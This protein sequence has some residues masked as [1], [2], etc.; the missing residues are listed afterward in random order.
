MRR[1]YQS[2]SVEQLEHLV[3]AARS[4]G[5]NKT[6]RL[7]ATELEKYRTTQKAKQLLQSLAGV[8]QEAPKPKAPKAEPKQASSSKAAKPS[9]AKAPPSRPSRKPTPEQQQAID[10]FLGRGSLKINAYAGTGKTSTLEMLAHASPARGQY[11]AFNRSIVVEAKERFPSTVDC[12][13]THRLALR[14]IPS[15]Y[16]ESRDKVFGRV[17][18]N[19]LAEVLGLKGNWRVDEGHSLQ[20]RSQAFM[21]LET[22]KRFAQSEDDELLP[23]HVPQHGSLLAASDESLARV[24]DFALHGAKHVWS[25]M[26]D[27]ADK[28][29]LGHDGYLKLWALSKPQIAADYILLD[30]AQDTNPVVLGVLRA[31]PC[32]MIYV[33]DRYQQI[34][35]WR[36]AVNAMDRIQTDAE[37]RLTQ[38]FRFGP[39]IADGAS[40]ILKLLGENVPLTGNPQKQ[41]RIGPCE[42]QT[43]LGRTN[44][45]AM[46]ALIEALNGGKRPHLV[47][48]TD[49]LMK[50]LNGVA[51]LKEGRPVPDV[52][53]FFGFNNWNEVVAFAK[54]PE[55]EQLQ[56]FVNL[57]QSHSERQLKWALHNSVEEEKS[58]LVISTAHKAKGREWENV[59]LMDDFLKSN[60]RAAK[61]K[62]ETEAERAAELRLFYV[63]MTR[64]KQVIEIPEP[65]LK[66]FGIAGVPGRAQSPA[67]TK[68]PAPTTHQPASF[69]R[70]PDELKASWAPPT[71][72]KPPEQK[73][74]PTKPVAAHPAVAAPQTKKRGF[75]GWL[76]GE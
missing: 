18:A 2:L 54:T 34:Y 6:L 55:G 59:R 13:T 42:P 46:V 35:E 44:A 47:G 53:E 67:P 5:D 68:P 39:A 37:V 51:E 16:R 23:S 57:V 9:K 20:P 45:S 8:K 15:A 17:N 30:E 76:L 12:S 28:I 60:P 29:P 64:A 69:G 22:I 62:Q 36:G 7:I 74:P 71:D 70:A 21:I 32:Q 52:P 40:T 72:W 33:G 24:R 11:I 58:N 41:S 26:L 1:P 3:T 66:A 43:V 73:S 63:A 50:M 31:Q 65:M 19:Q 48:G 10:L 49:E 4:S 27:P 38:S 75:F 56:T 25:R 14:S 61:A